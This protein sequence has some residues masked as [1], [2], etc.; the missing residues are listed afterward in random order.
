MKP[1]ENFTKEHDTA[2]LIFGT[3]NPVT[4]AHVNMGTTVSKLY[5][6]SDV[7]FVP[8][9]DAFL[10]NWKGFD[11]SAILKNRIDLLYTVA[12]KHGF[13]VSDIEL[14]GVVDGRSIHTIEYMK[15]TLGYS[16]ILFCMG[17][18]KLG[19]IGAWYRAKDLVSQN[20]FIVFERDPAKTVSACDLVKE[21]YG[22]FT[23]VKEDDVYTSISATEVRTCLSE[24]SFERIRETVPAEVYEHLKEIYK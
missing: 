21:Y 6:E 14:T 1:K 3:F 16:K 20:R 13:K 19:E 24:G 18:D 23:F 22:N 5:P 7:V 9:K 10:K 2:I 12:R 11:D 8:A 4:N 15:N 17:T